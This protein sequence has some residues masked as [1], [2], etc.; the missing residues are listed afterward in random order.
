[1]VPGIG[2]PVGRAL[3][4]GGF[5]VTVGDDVAG[6]VDV[7]RNGVGVTADRIGVQD[8]ASIEATA[9]VRQSLRTGQL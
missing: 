2:A 9:T 1:V 5:G 3:A 6:R 4:G 7:M 8:A